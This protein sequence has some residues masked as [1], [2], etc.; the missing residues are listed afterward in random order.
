MKQ[1]LARTIQVMSWIKGDFTEMPIK[2]Y[3]QFDDTALRPPIDG[4]LPRQT[5][6]VLGIHLDAMMNDGWFDHV[7]FYFWEDQYE[8]RLSRGAWVY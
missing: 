6:E 1:K 7:Y 4:P 2:T 5:V 8:L 3:A